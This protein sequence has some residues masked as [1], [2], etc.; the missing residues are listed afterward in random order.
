MTIEKTATVPAYSTRAIETSS[1][2]GDGLSMVCHL[3]EAGTADLGDVITDSQACPDALQARVQATNLIQPPS[4]PVPSLTAK[5]DIEAG[6]S[7][8]GGCPITLRCLDSPA[9]V[10][11]RG[12][13]VPTARHYNGWRV[14]RA[15]PHRHIATA[16]ATMCV[17]QRSAK[18]SR[19]NWR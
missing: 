3:A 13:C 19:Q 6:K 9:A 18:A 5:S 17:I 8:R 10:H 1:A 2:V 7:W 16:I 15:L 12:R 11:R 4:S 14:H